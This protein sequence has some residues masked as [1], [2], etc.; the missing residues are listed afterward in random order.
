MRETQHVTKGIQTVHV[1]NDLRRNAKEIKNG[2]RLYCLNASDAGGK[3]TL[4]IMLL[5]YISTVGGNEAIPSNLPTRQQLQCRL[6][7]THAL[8]KSKMNGTCIPH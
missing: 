6:S 2:R 3:Y 8:K 5:M 1:A 4:Y 7:R